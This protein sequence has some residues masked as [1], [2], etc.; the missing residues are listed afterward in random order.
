MMQI[1]NQ[2]PEG[3]TFYFLH[4]DKYGTEGQVLFKTNNLLDGFL[5]RLK[6]WTNNSFGKFCVLGEVP[7]LEIQ[8][9]LLLHSDFF[10][11]IMQN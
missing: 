10:D 4:Y 11:K 6:D 9:V 3:W 2:N 5:Q 7:N 8:G 1:V